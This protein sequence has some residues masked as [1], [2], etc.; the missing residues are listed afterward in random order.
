MNPPNPREQ[1]RCN[2]PARFHHAIALS[3]QF[4]PG[5][6]AGY[7]AVARLEYLLVPLAF[8]FDPSLRVLVKTTPVQ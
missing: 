4:G 2:G 6:I 5:A 3:G 8:G 1:V 7:S